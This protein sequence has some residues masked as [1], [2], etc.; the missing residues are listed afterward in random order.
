MRK[1]LAYLDLAERCR[2]LAGQVKEPRHKKELAGMARLWERA[3]AERAKQ[4][5]K[6]AR[7]APRKSK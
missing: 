4:L 7:K 5:G 1:G 6:P 2:Q 3:A